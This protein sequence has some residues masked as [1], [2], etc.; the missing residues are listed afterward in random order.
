MNRAV[1]RLTLANSIKVLHIPLT[2]VFTAEF[3][4]FALVKQRNQLTIHRLSDKMRTFVH[5]I[6]VLSQKQR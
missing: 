1:R 3:E 4:N 2:T 6:D 5:V